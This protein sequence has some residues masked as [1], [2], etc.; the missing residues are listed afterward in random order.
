MPATALTTADRRRLAHA[1]PSLRDADA[2]AI[3]SFIEAAWAEH[4]LARQFFF[5]KQQT[6]YEMLP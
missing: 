4:G 6:A 5:F 3:S 1:L 2:R